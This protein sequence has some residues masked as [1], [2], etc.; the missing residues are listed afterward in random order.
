MDAKINLLLSQLPR[1]AVATPP[2]LRTLDIDRNLTARYLRSGWLASVA[3]GAYTR[4]GDSPDWQ[5]ALWGLQ[6]AGCPVWAGGQTALELSGLGQN[7][8]MGAAPIT[9]FGDPGARLPKWAVGGPWRRPLTLFTPAL[10]NVTVAEST[11]FQT[12]TVA[13]IALT[14]STPE[15]AV[16]ELAYRVHDEAG[17]EPLDHAMQGLMTLRPAAMQSLLEKCRLV[18]VVRLVLLLAEHYGHP[19]VKR[20]DLSAL[21]LGSGK[22]QLWAGSSIHPKYLIS[23]P[24]GFLNGSV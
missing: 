14:I 6:K 12:L 4:S 9:L 3:T 23:V 19:W 13:E 5:G 16:L 7:L 20:V 11:S 1:A 18:R 2:W 8:A 17:F 15:R 21:D 22:R 24:K 10:L